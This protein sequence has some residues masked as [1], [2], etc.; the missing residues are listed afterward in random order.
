MKTTLEHKYKKYI[1]LLPSIDQNK[2]LGGTE[3]M[4]IVVKLLKK[5]VYWY[6]NARHQEYYD[7]E[8]SLFKRKVGKKR[9][10]YDVIIRD[11][12]NEINNI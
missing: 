4:V 10:E 12:Y 6:Y 9:D 7:K 8:F 11:V 3:D 2:V 5:A 1:D